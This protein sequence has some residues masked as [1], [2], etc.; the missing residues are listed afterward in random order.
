MTKLSECQVA[1]VRN[2]VERRMPC[3][4]C[5]SKSTHR[6]IA[7]RF[8]VSRVWVT[9]IANGKAHRPNGAIIGG[10]S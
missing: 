4:T 6:S 7:Y 1:A 3:P 2:A 5:G 10:A 9:L 8:G